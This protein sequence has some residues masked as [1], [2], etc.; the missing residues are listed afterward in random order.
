M[1]PVTLRAGMIYGRGVL[2]IEAARWLLRHHLL[3]VWR[4]PTWTHLLA[5]PDFLSCVA[6]A[7]EGDAVSGIYNLGDDEPLTLQEF[8]DTVANHWGFRKPWRSPKWSFYFAAACC[9][10]YAMIFRTRSP[11]TRDFIKIGMVSC[12]ADTS[13]MKKELLPELAFPFLKKGLPL[14]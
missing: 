6:S 2:M 4:K 8:L 12:V 9:E 1:V 13:R 5:L 11:L 10:T 7:I 14:L 3:A